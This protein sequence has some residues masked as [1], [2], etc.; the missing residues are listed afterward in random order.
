MR[1]EP[2]RSAALQRLQGF[3]PQAGRAYSEG[4]N[5]DRG[6]GQRDR[7]SQLSPYLRHRLITE[8]EVTA[9]VLERHT[10]S[11]A[12]KF[13][14][15]VCWRTYWKGWLERRP[16]V[17]SGYQAALEA[18]E[19]LRAA[20]ED[21]DRRL[22][23]AETGATGI[24]C[25][26]AWVAELVEYG[27]LH[28]HTR[29]WFASIWVFTLELPWEAGADF[30]LRHLLDGDPAS[31]T[32]SWRWVAGLHTP[33][34]HYLARASNI[35][36]YT[37]GRFNPAGALREDARGPAPA[38]LPESRPLPR[39]T[40]LRRGLRS[41]VLLT[42][43]DLCAE[44]WRIEDIQPV[45]VGGWAQPEHRSRRPV[46]P[47]VTQFVSGALD[48]G[49]SRAAHHWGVSA[50]RLSETSLA[51]WL[52]E[53]RISQLLLP[54]TCVGPGEEGLR[55]LRLAAERAG[56]HVAELRRDWDEAFWPHAGRGFFQ[57]KAK[58]DDVLRSLGLNGA[59]RELAFERSL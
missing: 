17:W 22:N 37:D 14:Q 26:D 3:L 36:K 58:I 28:N 55:P 41:A 45:A 6:P 50:R 49:L 24:A 18:L 20:D 2:T 23:A 9:A 57:L 1:F 7:V 42:E 33:G 11:S 44:Q 52:G 21:L 15:E 48:D 16:T 56:V 27:Y 39:T 47:A 53:Q 8:A 4:R 34:K 54:W 30:F 5:H 32:L 43:D 35:E 38:A 31:N 25:F 40:P 10:A 19:G 46:S 59:Q 29:M 13:I 51:E 12:E